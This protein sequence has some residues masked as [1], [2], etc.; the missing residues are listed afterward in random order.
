MS[1]IPSGR[2]LVVRSSRI[3]RC[4]KKPGATGRRKRRA[5]SRL[6]KRGQLMNCGPPDNI[7]LLTSDGLRLLL[8]LAV[9]Q[10]RRR[11]WGR[12]MMANQSQEKESCSRSVIRRWSFFAYGWYL[13]SAGKIGQGDASATGS[14]VLL[15]LAATDRLAKQGN[16]E[17][18]RC[19]TADHPTSRRSCHDHL[20]SR[21]WF[22]C[23]A[24]VTHRT[25]GTI[26]RTAGQPSFVA[27][28]RLT[29]L[30]DFDN[31]SLV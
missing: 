23:N 10:V 20:G 2:P 28:V 1:E 11:T 9:G 12:W 7:K 14:S 30:D 18:R 8:G 15:C 25:V 16:F 22:V 31:L 13:L 19:G 17:W 21:L 27:Q 5:N 3:L 4:L 29:K 24:C 6:I 26:Q